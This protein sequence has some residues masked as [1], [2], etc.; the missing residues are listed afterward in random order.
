V[1]VP[2]TLA[3]WAGMGYGPHSLTP[4][5]PE[6]GDAEDKMQF[7]PGLYRIIK[8]NEKGVLAYP[9]YTTILLFL[10]FPPDGYLVGFFEMAQLLEILEIREMV[11]LLNYKY[12]TSLCPLPKY[13]NYFHSV[14]IFLISNN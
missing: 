13:L 11:K 6:L 5:T 1:T 8:K 2:V 14:E 10:D 12:W 7:Y 9:P 4:Y 3:E